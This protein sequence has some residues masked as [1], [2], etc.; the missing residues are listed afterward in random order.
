MATV[1]GAPRVTGDLDYT[2]VIPATKA[3]ELE[4]LAGLDSPLHRKHRVHLRRVSVEDVPEDYSERLG[5]VFPG[6]FHHLRLLVPDPYDLALSKL[7][8]NS[9]KDR[10]DVRFLVGNLKLDPAILE[11]RYRK[12]LRPNLSNQERHDLTLKLWLEDYLGQ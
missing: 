1:F 5:E 7:R 2:E 12:E 6:K 4:V 9:A 8:R 10:E 3:T 11:E